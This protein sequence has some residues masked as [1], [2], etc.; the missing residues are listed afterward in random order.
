VAEGGMIETWRGAVSAWECDAFGHLNIA[1][2]PDRFHEAALNLVETLAREAGRPGERWRTT[3]MYVRYPKELRAGAGMAIRSGVLAA[4]GD[5]TLTIG[6]E[7]L[8]P[9][10]GAIVTT[11]EHRLGPREPRGGA[12]PAPA[13]GGLAWSGQPFAALDLPAE[14]GNLPTGRDRIKAW[15]VDEQGELSL[16]GYVQ[17]FSTACLHVLDAMGVTSAYMREARRGFA[18]FETR[19]DIAGFR[20]RAGE[21]LTITSGVV[22][23]G[24]SSIKMRHDMDETGSGCRVATFF[25]AGVHFDLDTRRSAALPPEMKARAEAIRLGRMS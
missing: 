6:H 5:G 19:L 4:G 20:P 23:I 25:Q 8:E 9:A 18:T 24:N 15:E 7:A 12:L 11:V 16:T 14:E 17:R 21:G 3:A 2:Y 22:E 13:G 1:F 10:S